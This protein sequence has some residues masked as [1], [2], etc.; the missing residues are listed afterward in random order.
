MR[1]IAQLVEQPPLK[2]GYIATVAGSSPAFSPSLKLGWN[3][4]YLNVAWELRVIPID[5]EIVNKCDELL[6]KISY[7][8][9][10]KNS[11]KKEGISA[12]CIPNLNKGSEII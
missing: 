9:W 1:E 12:K 7:K 8:A 5:M 11:S 6:I 3:D 2:T 4:I 10:S